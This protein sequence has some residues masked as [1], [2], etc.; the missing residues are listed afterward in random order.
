[1]N[2]IKEAYDFAVTKWPENFKQDRFL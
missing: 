2:W 1:M